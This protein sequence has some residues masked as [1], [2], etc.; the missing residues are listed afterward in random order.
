MGLLRAVCLAAQT[1]E[2]WVVHSAAKMAAAK[3]FQWVVWRVGCLAGAWAVMK[4]VSMVVQMVECLVAQWDL[5]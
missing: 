2:C 5:K 4:A 3:V 1:V